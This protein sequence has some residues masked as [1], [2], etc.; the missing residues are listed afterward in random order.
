MNH[1][2]T[3]DLSRVEVLLPPMARLLI[4]VIGLR[5]TTELVRVAG[6][7]TIAIPL[8]ETRAGEARYESIVELIGPDAADSLVQNFGGE[9]IYIPRCHVALTECVYREI[10]R[11]FDHITRGTSS[12]QAV[13]TLATRYG[14]SDRH[15]WS[16]LK[17][18]DR[19][20]VPDPARNAGQ[21]GLI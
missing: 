4:T 3:P 18:S 7:T 19:S 21:L 13:A 9:A 12:V 17:M 10:R 16:I 14:Y 2:V 1:P 5:A 6:G 8:R 15:I 11:S 20:D